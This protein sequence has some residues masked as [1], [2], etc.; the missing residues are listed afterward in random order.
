MWRSMILHL[1]L[2]SAVTLGMVRFNIGNKKESED[3][4]KYIFKKAAIVLFYT[5]YLTFT[6]LLAKR[7][8]FLIRNDYKE[9]ENNYIWIYCLA[10]AFIWFSGIFKNRNG[11]KKLP[12]R[13]VEGITKHAAFF[14]VTIL[15]FCTQ[16]LERLHIS[17]FGTGVMVLGI[18]GVITLIG[19]RY[20]DKE[21]TLN[22]QD[23]LLLYL[24]TCVMWYLGTALFNPSA[25]DMYGYVPISIFATFVPVIFIL[26]IT[27]SFNLTVYI[28][29]LINLVWTFTHYLVYQFRGTVFLPVDILVTKTALNVAGQYNYEL[30][31]EI[32][33]F[34]MFS[35]I[36]I[37]L[38]GNIKKIKVQ[39]RR[40]VFRIIGIVV[41]G[42]SVLIWYHTDFIS[43]MHLPDDPM[44]SHNSL[45]NKVGYT[46]GFIQVMKS[47]KVIPPDNYSIDYVEELAVKYAYEPNESNVIKPNI[48]VIMNE[49]F[50]DVADLG[51]VDTN[52]DYMP[53][54][55]SLQTSGNTAVGRTLVS[56]YGGGT[57]NS[58][59]EFLTGN[60]QEFRPANYPYLTEIRSNIYSFVS[61]LK[62]QGYYSIATHPNEGD[63]YRRDTIYKYM[64]FDEMHFID[65]YENPEYIHERVSDA[66]VY[67]NILSWMNNR[68]S[69]G[70][71]FTFAVTI[72]NH[73]GYKLGY[74]RAG[75]ELIIK[76]KNPGASIQLDEYL[77]LMY[78]SDKAFED[79]IKTIDEFEEPTVVVM[80]GD[81]FP[82]IQG[83]MWNS[84]VLDDKDAEEIERIKYSPPYIIHANYDIDMSIIPD[85][86]SVNYL[87]SNILKVCGLKMT[88]YD[89]YLLNMEEEIP[90]LNVLGLLTKEGKWYEYSE[91]Y[92]DEYQD[93]LNEYNILQYN[94]RYK[95]SLPQMFAVQ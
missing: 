77:S 13:I 73:G 9:S 69:E 87:A 11:D 29:V 60:S 19:Y 20:S 41:T 15:A 14:V 78:E 22:I 24:L 6:R 81:H 49:T 76:Q 27:A 1:M 10:G 42:I 88:A 72:Q 83:E 30:N 65:D 43:Y 32:W 89:N 18:Y 70:P 36:M 25:E 51:E 50:V 26:F 79:L 37:M 62:E 53:Y 38:S 84:I 85:Y 56:V 59:Y 5:F 58:E 35:V 82:M 12:A 86:L 4:K 7:L 44:M 52:I 93:K 46:M 68:E 47:S 92:P 16:E 64:Q 34:C 23:V 90:A 21:R 39:N 40:R 3:I 55:H 2:V 45:Y 71:C 95:D 91:G 57:S 74:A 33:K 61:T 8:T 31:T 48:I 80:F 66:E 67:K 94:A 28:S 17:T 54:F 75:E 63:F